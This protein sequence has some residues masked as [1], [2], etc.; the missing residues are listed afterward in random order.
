M[1]KGRPRRSAKPMPDTI[2]KKYPY[3]FILHQYHLTTL[4]AV[5]PPYRPAVIQF[6][7]LSMLVRNR[8]SV[9]PMMTNTV[10]TR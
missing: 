6:T 8:P 1:T 5:Y 7:M 2:P 10:D 4:A 9:V 3:P